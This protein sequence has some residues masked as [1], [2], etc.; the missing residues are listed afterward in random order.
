ML[1]CRC[2]CLWRQRQSL[3][4]GSERSGYRNFLKARQGPFLSIDYRPREKLESWIYKRTDS[5]SVGIDRCFNPGLRTNYTEE[6]TSVSL[7]LPDS[8]RPS[9]L[10]THEWFGAQ[11]STCRMWWVTYLVRSES[12]FHMRA[13]ATERVWTQT[14][15]SSIQAHRMNLYRMKFSGL[16]PIPRKTINMSARDAIAI[17]Y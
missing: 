7:P 15:S 6:V 17:Q 16:Y 8:A 11:R 5:S 1:S 14:C 13:T 9:G 10:V 12:S 2:P 3:G 4:E